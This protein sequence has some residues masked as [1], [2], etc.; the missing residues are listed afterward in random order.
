L[1]TPSADRRRCQH[2]KIRRKALALGHGISDPT[3]RRVAEIARQLRLRDIGGI[4][5]I[6][7]IDMDRPEQREQLLA[8]LR[9]ELKKDRTRPTWW[10]SPNSDWLK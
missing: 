10:G 6:D 1:I 9:K 4:I 7:F 2:R 3:A 8:L 5:V